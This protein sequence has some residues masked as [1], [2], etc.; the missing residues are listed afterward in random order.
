M[1][2]GLKYQIELS[3]DI[4][5]FFVEDNLYRKYTEKYV[6]STKGKCVEVNSGQKPRGTGLIPQIVVKFISMK[7]RLRTFHNGGGDL[8]SSFLKE[9]R[10]IPNFDGKHFKNVVSA[11]EK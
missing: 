3:F 8:G 11:L 6:V 4:H 7:I 10:L 1:P 2:R 9:G 5:L